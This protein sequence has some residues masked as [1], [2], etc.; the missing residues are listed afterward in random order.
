MGNSKSKP[1]TYLSEKD[2]V[3]LES[4]TQFKREKI[5]EWHNAFLHDC[6]DGI[7][8]RK[9]FIKLYSQL[10]ASDKKIEKY[11]EFVF[12]GKFYLI[13]FI[14]YSVFGIRFY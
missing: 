1:R 12:T 5:I 14:D 9:Q 4:N 13:F 11:A 6:P 7:L 8:D 10:E 3:F 2:L